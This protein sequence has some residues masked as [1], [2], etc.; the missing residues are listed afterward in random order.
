MLCFQNLPTF[1]K[2]YGYLE[3]EQGM[4]IIFVLTLYLQCGGIN[5]QQYVQWREGGLAFEM[6]EGVYQMTNPSLL[7]SRVFSQVSVRLFSYMT[8]LHYAAIR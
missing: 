7:S 1:L 2:K 6:R 4:N 3:V 8:F 5:K